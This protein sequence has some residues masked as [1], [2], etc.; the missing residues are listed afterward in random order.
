M[1]QRCDCSSVVCEPEDCSSRG[2]A[3]S[4]QSLGS[5]EEQGCCSKLGSLGVIRLP[6][7]IVAGARGLEGQG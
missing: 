3:N 5:C 4:K 1:K 7:L 6:K 2:F